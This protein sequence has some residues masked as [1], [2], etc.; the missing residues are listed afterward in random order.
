MVIY[1]LQD[2]EPHQ[3]LRQIF[4]L[5]DYNGNG[6]LSRSE[7]D[8]AVV[9]LYPHLAVGET[10]KTAAID[11]AYEAVEIYRAYNSVENFNKVTLFHTF[12]VL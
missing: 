3:W 2:I 1:C 5:F 11:E 9:E 6:L 10:T 4:D 12:I 7:V 8:K